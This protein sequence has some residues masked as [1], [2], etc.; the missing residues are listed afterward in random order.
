MLLLTHK[1]LDGAPEKPKM[2]R[3][4]KEIDYGLF[5]ELCKIRCTEQEVCNVLGVSKDALLDRLKEHYFDEE[6]G[7]PLTFEKVFNRYADF[8]IMSLRREQFR[9]AIKKGNIYMQI[10]LGKQYLGQRDKYDATS[11]G[12]GLRP[13]NLIVNNQKTVD[14][15]QAIVETVT[16]K[17][18][19]EKTEADQPSL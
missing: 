11:G 19:S 3:P 10:W 4:R 1:K 14:N 13:V 6:T 16:A 8:G 7:E 9:S 5:E 15:I 2:G 18:I 12:S 17:A